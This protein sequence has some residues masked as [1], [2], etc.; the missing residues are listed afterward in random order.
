MYKKK[1]KTERTCL[2]CGGGYVGGLGVGVTTVILI[3]FNKPIILKIK[4]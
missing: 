2:L 1:T 3:N 4:T